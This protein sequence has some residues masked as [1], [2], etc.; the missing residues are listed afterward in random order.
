MI[1]AENLEPGEGSFLDDGIKQRVLQE[2]FGI[3]SNTPNRLFRSLVVASLMLEGSEEENKGKLPTSLEPQELKDFA[4]MI[5]A[6]VEEMLKEARALTPDDIVKGVRERVTQLKEDSSIGVE[7]KPTLDQMLASLEGDNGVEF[8][9]EFLRDLPSLPKVSKWKASPQ[10]LTEMTKGRGNITERF[11]ESISRG[12]NLGRGNQLV[13]VTP[14]G[15]NF[16]QDTKETP[17][18]RIDLSAI[19]GRSKA[20]ATLLAAATT[21]L[22]FRLSF[23]NLVK[24]VEA[25]DPQSGVWGALGIELLEAVLVFVAATDGLASPKDSRREALMKKASILL[26][27]TLI[28]TLDT[29][30]ILYAGYGGL[31]NEPIIQDMPIFVSNATKIT[32]AALGAIWPNFGFNLTLGYLGNWLRERRGNGKQPS[33]VRSG[34]A[35]IV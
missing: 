10:P 28:F 7:L 32:I 26:L 13:F 15:V 11:A 20:V 21:Y 14:E 8:A 31:N 17:I 6:G 34:K 9:E 4:L 25:V 22:F 5:K 27:S 33:A 19:T 35:E 29:L 3:N 12:L 16:Q 1:S 18:Y 2:V 24:T 23:N 30:G